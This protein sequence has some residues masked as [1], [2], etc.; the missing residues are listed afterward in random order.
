MR[1]TVPAVL[2]RLCEFSRWSS[3]P[4][5][6]RLQPRA[7]PPLHV[8]SVG[9]LLLYVRRRLA[10]S[11]SC[12]AGPPRCLRAVG[13]VPATIMPFPPPQTDEHRNGGGKRTRLMGCARDRHDRMQP[14]LEAV[15]VPHFVDASHNGSTAEGRL[16]PG[17]IRCEIEGINILQGNE[18]SVSPWISFDKKNLGFD[19][20][21]WNVHCTSHGLQYR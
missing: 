19:R 2:L 12:V 5:R 11:W 10:S 8:L 3:S 14:P 21:N 18:F 13:P 16:N 1:D 15:I 17:T 4:S 20:K 7:H 9:I 6:R